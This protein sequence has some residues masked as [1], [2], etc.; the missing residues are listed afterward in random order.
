MLHLTITKLNSDRTRLRKEVHQQSKLTKHLRGIIVDLKKELL[1]KG[2]DFTIKLSTLKI[3]IQSLKEKI[4][5]LSDF[6][7][8]TDCF[9]F[10]HDDFEIDDVVSDS[11]R[12]QKPS[13]VLDNTKRTIKRKRKLKSNQPVRKRKSTRSKK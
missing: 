8:L 2:T 3:Q 11:S 6:K 4:K 7:S 9:D 5:S 10:T 1:R 12:I 13:E